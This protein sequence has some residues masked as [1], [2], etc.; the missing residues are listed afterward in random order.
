MLHRRWT[1]LATKQSSPIFFLFMILIGA[2]LALLPPASRR[3]NSRFSRLAKL[4]AV[5]AGAL[6]ILWGF[7]F[8][9]FPE[10]NAGREVFNRPLAAK[11]ADVRSPV[12]RYVL[13]AMA[14]T[15]VVPRAYIWGFADSIRAGL[16]GRVE[17]IRVLATRISGRHR[18]IFPQQ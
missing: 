7:Y 6:I 18:D 2:I 9:R 3:E 10:S 4:S 13:N 5:A 17:P 15:Y 11:I 1:G 16:E 14:S 12:Y 8:I